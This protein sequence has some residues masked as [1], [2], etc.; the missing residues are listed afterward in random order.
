MFSQ[1]LIDEV[2][3]D[4]SAVGYALEIFFS[5]GTSR[6]HTGV[7]EILINGDTYYG[8]GELGS[9]GVVESV[10]DENPTELSLELSGIDATLLGAALD[11]EARGQNVVL[12]VIVFSS[13]TG[14]LVIAEPAMRGF[15]TSY[16]VLAG[17][18]NRIQMSV[19]DEFQRYEMPWDRFW[20]DESHRNDEGGDRLCRYTSQMEEREIQW[21]SKNDAPPFRY[22]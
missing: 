14:Q 20:T 12:Y 5:S 22:E 21:G 19:A 7:G 4:G 1:Q 3:A 10:G 13:I 15:I 6:M 2:S 18:D 8:V 17:S 9:V 16:S 11:A